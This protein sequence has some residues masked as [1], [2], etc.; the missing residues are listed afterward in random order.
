MAA[1]AAAA[2]CPGGASS[3]VEHLVPDT[4]RRVDR[5]AATMVTRRYLFARYHYRRQQ[6]WKYV[7]L[8]TTAAGIV[9]G[10]A[11]IAVNSLLDSD[12]HATFLRYFNVLFSGLLITC[13]HKFI[14]YLAPQQRREQHEKAGDMY[15]S[16]ATTLYREVFITGDGTASA[17]GAILDKHD[18]HLANIRATHEQP[19]ADDVQADLVALSRMPHMVIQ[20]FGDFQRLLLPVTPDNDST[21]V[22][23]TGGGGGG[24]DVTTINVS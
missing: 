9:A 18:A 8:V 22:V 12:D 24:G 20:Q 6:F 4:L 14:E 16:M 17:I 7:L 10:G 3:L 15:M 5:Q 1:A 13:T 2:T 11:V 23:M 21:N 19:P